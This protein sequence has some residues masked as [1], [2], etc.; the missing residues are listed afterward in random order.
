MSARHR[1]PPGMGVPGWESNYPEPV[2][3][4]IM[5]LNDLLRAKWQF[6]NA[7]DKSFKIS[8]TTL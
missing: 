1:R 7:F 3:S 6:F 4:R 2:L 5:T 8:R